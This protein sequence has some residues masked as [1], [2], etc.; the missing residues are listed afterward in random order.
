MVLGH[1]GVGRSRGDSELPISDFD[2]PI[3]M[4]LN[5]LKGPPADDLNIPTW[6]TLNWYVN[7]CLSNEIQ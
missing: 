7:Y 6:Y 5:M 2:E 3:K 1:Q 4:V